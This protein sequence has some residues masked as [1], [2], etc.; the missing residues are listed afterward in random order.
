MYWN[1]LQ[2]WVWVQ[3][4]RWKMYSERLRLKELV[5]EIRCDGCW[6]IMIDI[7][8]RYCS[9]PFFLMKML[10]ITNLHLLLLLKWSMVSLFNVCFETFI[11]GYFILAFIY[12]NTIKSILSNFDT[13]NHEHFC[14]LHLFCYA[15]SFIDLD[16]LQM[17]F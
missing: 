1:I 2:N 15:F 5:V 17:L 9:L 6:I 11:Q 3:S 14:I 16:I 7:R 12:H 10:G 8:T 4:V 13:L